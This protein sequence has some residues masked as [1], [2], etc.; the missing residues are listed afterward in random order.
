MLIAAKSGFKRHIYI[1]FRAFG[2]GLARM[3][4]DLACL[5]PT[6]EPRFNVALVLRQLSRSV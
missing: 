1:D 4:G 2:E 6:Y 3:L 5:L